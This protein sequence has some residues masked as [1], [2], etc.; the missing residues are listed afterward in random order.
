MPEL[1]EAETVARALG[2]AVRG[3]KIAKVEIFAS[4]LR[5]PLAP[6]CRAKLEGRTI[7]GCRRRARYAVADLDDGRTLVFHFGM[8]GTVRVEDRAQARRKHDHVE[9]ALDDGR[10]LRFNDPRRFGSLEVQACGADG[11]PESLAGMGVEPLTEAF[12]GD[13]LYRASRGR[14]KSVKELLM[15]NAVVTGIGNIYA[16][17]TLFAC[18]IRPQRKAASLTHAQC[19]ALAREAKRILARA[20][21]RGGTTV[22]DFKSVDGAE[23]RFVQELKIYGQPACP[24]CGAKVAK[25]VLGGRTSWYCPSCQE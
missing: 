23:G 17:E 18:G 12:T 2:R 9:M 22:H 8:S 1:P 10:V 3:R 16:A 4:K 13:V 6:L 24:A 20:I 5:T 7:T 25:V 15:D 14:R 21:E 19:D 11:W